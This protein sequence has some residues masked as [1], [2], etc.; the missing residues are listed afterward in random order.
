VQDSVIKVLFLFFSF[1]LFGCPKESALR[2]VKL[3]K[4]QQ[5]VKTATSDP[6]H[7]NGNVGNLLEFKRIFLSENR[8]PFP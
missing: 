5:T 7:W 4:I 2:I 8:A 1:P 6:V 3:G